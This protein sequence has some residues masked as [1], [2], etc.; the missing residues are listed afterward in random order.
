L[1]RK[2]KTY[3]GEKKTFSTNDA[4]KTGNLHAEE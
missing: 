4:G 1:T 3:I 2:P